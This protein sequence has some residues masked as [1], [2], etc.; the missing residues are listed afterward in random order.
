MCGRALN[1]M[2][3]VRMVFREL[4]ITNSSTPSLGAGIVS[5]GEHDSTQRGG[6]AGTILP[7]DRR[8]RSRIL[9]LL[10]FPSLSQS[11][12]ERWSLPALRSSRSFMAS[13]AVFAY[14]G[15]A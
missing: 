13:P 10:R 2:V 7:R 4:A 14:P 3:R 8:V 9:K 1:F 11:A 5:T 6:Q 15:P 12:R